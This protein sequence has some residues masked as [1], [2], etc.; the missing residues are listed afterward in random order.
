[1]TEKLEEQR[2]EREGEDI[3]HLS[4]K[5][6]DLDFLV[7]HPVDD[8]F[9]IKTIDSE[10]LDK[11]VIADGKKKYLYKMSA[12]SDSFFKAL[13]LHDERLEYS[14]KLFSY[15]L[16]CSYEYLKENLRLEK[17]IL[18]KEQDSDKGNEGD[19][20]S[21]IKD[22]YLSIEVN[23]SSEESIT[24]R[25]ILYS[26]KLMNRSNRKGVNDKDATRIQSIMFSINNYAREGIDDVVRL[27]TYKDDK[28]VV[29]SN[30]P[31]T[32]E[33]FL[34]NIVK[35]VYNRDKDGHLV[36]DESKK[37]ELKKLTEFEKMMLIAIEQN[38]E[39]C[40]KIGKGDAFLERF[41]EDA[42]EIS[43]DEDLLESY[44]KAEA[45]KRLARDEG[46]EQGVKQ[47]VSQNRREV[48][49]DMLKENEPIEKIIKYSKL[50][51]QEILEIKKDL[52]I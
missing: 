44:N 4:L 23:N 46:V 43:R 19:F 35:K 14:A 49:E 45:D 12:V 37:E 47:G 17:N 34:S 1:M 27:V 6:Y 25:N 22:T 42:V 51:E 28:N 11:Y 36:F 20:V 52:K 41:L 50:T 26:F 15:F 31:M 30:T 3:E 7:S 40:E 9:R 13:F 18:N 10:K 24:K 32:L 48:A 8:T 5:E 16:D 21:K 2:I 29:Y 38:V 39:V 33:I